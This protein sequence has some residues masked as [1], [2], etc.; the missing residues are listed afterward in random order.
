M[1]TACSV[2]TNT[3]SSMVAMVRKGA[4]YAQAI[5]GIMLMGWWW[6]MG[7]H[8]VY[9][10]SCSCALFLFPVHFLLFFFSSW[11]WLPS[12][13]LNCGHSSAAIGSSSSFIAP[14]FFEVV[15]TRGRGGITWISFCFACCCSLGFR[16]NRTG[17]GISESDVV[18]VVCGINTSEEEGS[19][20]FRMLYRVGSGMIIVV[21]RSSLSVGTKRKPISSS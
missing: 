5:R 16:V 2:E 19:F 11:W 8:T 1:A 17:G 3:M 12:F 15:A 20:F 7:K 9:I 6:F 21:S 13:F 14:K 4:G 10:Q 18:V